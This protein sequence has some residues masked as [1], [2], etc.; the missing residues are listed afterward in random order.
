MSARELFTGT[1]EWEVDV[2][3]DGHNEA[4]SES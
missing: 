1:P 3:V 2:L 4:N